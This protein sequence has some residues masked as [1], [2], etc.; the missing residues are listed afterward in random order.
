MWAHNINLWP[1]SILIYFLIF[2]L[3]CAYVYPCTCHVVNSV[4][5]F[6]ILYVSHVCGHVSVHICPNLYLHFCTM[7]GMVLLDGTIRLP[8][9]MQTSNSFLVLLYSYN[10]TIFY[11]PYIYILYPFIYLQCSIVQWKCDWLCVTCLQG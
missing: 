2:V 11:N 9:H 4:H 8:S 5:R 1:Y 3:V 10:S 6:I 7:H